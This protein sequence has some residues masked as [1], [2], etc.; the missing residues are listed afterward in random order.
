MNRPRKDGYAVTE[1]NKALA[2]MLFLIVT[3]LDC[4]EPSARFADDVHRISILMR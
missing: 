3:K 1:R 4:A 2:D